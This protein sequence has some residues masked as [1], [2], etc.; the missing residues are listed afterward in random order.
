MNRIPPL[1]A[2]RVLAGLLP[3]RYAEEYAK[4]GRYGIILIILL[5]VSGILHQILVTVLDLVVKLL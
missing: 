3:D 5:M 2:S 1:D 4:L